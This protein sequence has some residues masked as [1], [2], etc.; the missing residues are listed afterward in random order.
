MVKG[1]GVEDHV[2]V[3]GYGVVGQ[4]VVEVLMEHNV[5]FVVIEIDPKKVEHLKEQGYGVLEGDATYSRMLKMAGIDTAKAIAVVL[6]DDA[7][8]LFTVLAAHDLNKRLFI[9]ARANDEFVREKL[10]EAGADYIV[11][12]QRTASREIINNITKTKS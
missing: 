5:S 9:T 7:K 6:D 11:M 8:N 2:I 12:P 4:K 3:C 1:I 10:I